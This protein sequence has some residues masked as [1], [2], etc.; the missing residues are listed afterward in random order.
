MNTVGVSSGQIQQWGYWAIDAVN[1]KGN[2]GTNT[3]S[4]G[5][6]LLNVVRT[7]RVTLGKIHRVGVFYRFL[8]AVNTDRIALGQ[9]LSQKKNYTTG[10]WDLLNLVRITREKE[11]S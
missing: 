10:L 3:Y 1:C 11:H 8:H 9:I 6:I 4:R 2:F 5:D 7:V